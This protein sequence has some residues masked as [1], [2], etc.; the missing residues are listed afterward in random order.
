M[1]S[2]ELQPR[3]EDTGTRAGAAAGPEA[4]A[5]ALAFGADDETCCLRQH[6]ASSSG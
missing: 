2:Q 5:V 4:V 1:Q 6:V 3:H